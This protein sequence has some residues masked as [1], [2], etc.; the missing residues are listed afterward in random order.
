VEN[1]ELIGQLLD[2]INDEIGELD[3]II[4]LQ[5]HAPAGET[6]RVAKPP[7]NRRP[8]WATRVALLGR[9]ATSSMLTL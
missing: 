8:R 5:I 6:A 9:S 3:A 2:K 4:V 7:G 1:T